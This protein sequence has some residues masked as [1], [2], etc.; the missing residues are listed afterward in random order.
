[1]TH[2]RVF[3][4][5]CINIMLSIEGFTIVSF[6]NC[7]DQRLYE[8][9]MTPSVQPPKPLTPEGKLRYADGILDATRQRII[10]VQ[11]DHSG[12]GEAVNSIV[13]VCEQASSILQ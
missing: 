8:Q 3:N 11:E 1:M 10:I 7:R 6:R 4:A 13:A 2:P 12:S 9:A 5:F